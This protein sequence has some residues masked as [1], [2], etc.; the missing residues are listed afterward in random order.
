MKSILF[1][2]THFALIAAAARWSL[3]GYIICF[4]FIFSAAFLV[5]YATWRHLASNRL[6]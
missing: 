1:I 3:V 5:L 6:L 2:L 4:L